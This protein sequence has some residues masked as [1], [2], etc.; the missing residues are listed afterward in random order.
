MARSSAQAEQDLQVLAEID[1]G[2]KQVRRVCKKI[3]TERV[4]ERDAAAA[5]YQ[6]LPLVQR[7]SVPQGV[8]APPAAV[9][10]VEGGRLQIF[11]RSPG[12][13][14]NSVPEEIQD[15]TIVPETEPTK[16]HWRED[17]IG[18]L[19]TLQSEEKTSDPCPEIPEHF[20]DPGWIPD[21]AKELNP[22]R[23][24]QSKNEPATAPPHAP[25]GSAADQRCRCAERAG[26]EVDA[27]S[28]DERSDRDPSAVGCRR[29]DGGGVG[30][31]LLRGI[32]ASVRRRRSGEQLDALANPRRVRSVV[33]AALGY[34]QRNKDR[35][36]YAEYRQRGLPIVSS[37]VES[38][39]KQFNCRV[40]G[41]DKFWRER[42]P[43]RCCHCVPTT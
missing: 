26:G 6:E 33:G 2:D 24:A 14:T 12:N 31:G 1:I 40:K 3:S 39:V 8:T 27:G 17:K 22:R 41:T 37:Y 25:R 43:R 13:S 34:L 15:D 16:K 20:V 36:R 21:L 29:A 7:K 32:E 30:S 4:A 10:G 38:A 42:G 19:L 18:V 35:M 23:S 5:A 11:E 9:V 28:L